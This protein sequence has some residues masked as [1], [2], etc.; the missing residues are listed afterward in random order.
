MERMDKAEIKIHDIQR[1]EV[2]ISTLLEWRNS[3]IARRVVEAKKW[4]KEGM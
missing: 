1:L 3:L 4:I 2:R